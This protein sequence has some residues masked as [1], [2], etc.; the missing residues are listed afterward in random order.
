MKPLFAVLLLLAPM[1]GA[2]A[3]EPDLDLLAVGPA[4]VAVGGSVHLSLTVAPRAGQHLLE[5][6]PFDVRILVAHSGLEATQTIYR[7]SEAVDAK[8]EAP[9][10]DIEVKGKH[11]GAGRVTAL[12]R[13]YLC[14]AQQCRPLETK[15]SWPL[16]VR[17]ATQSR[18]ELK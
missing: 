4:T 14:A 1:S 8:A 12:V 9:R 17:S 13:V 2:R 7:R 10:F 3:E 5:G 16:E 6:G 18:P 11:P 15:T